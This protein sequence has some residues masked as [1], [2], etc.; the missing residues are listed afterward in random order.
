MGKIPK[1]ELL[2]NRKMANIERE[3]QPALYE[4]SFD[5]ADID[6]GPEHLLNLKILKITMTI[7]ES[8]PELSKYLEEM[9]ET[10]PNEGDSVVTTEQLTSYYN[11]LETMLNT[12][13]TEE[14]VKQ[15]N[16]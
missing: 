4:Q 10:I 1:E 8:Y 11:S 9:T 6:K 5:A 14:F 16:D 3:I 7:R 12:Y 2:L 13:I 15:N